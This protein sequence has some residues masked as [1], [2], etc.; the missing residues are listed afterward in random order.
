MVLVQ[1]YHNVLLY[2]FLHLVLWVGGS[3]GQ[4]NEKS[5]SYGN[6]CFHLDYFPVE[7]TS[8]EKCFLSD[9]GI[10]FGKKH[11]AVEFFKC[12]F[13]MFWAAQTQVHLLILERAEISKKDISDH[14]QI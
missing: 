10:V 9:W 6:S 11:V 1:A 7:D 13:L 3:G 14:L 2:R 5:S 12:Q 8:S 4:Q